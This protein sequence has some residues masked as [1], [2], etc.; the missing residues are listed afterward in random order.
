MVG[1]H[2][3][4]DIRQRLTAFEVDG[5]G[6]GEKGDFPVK[7][8]SARLA[9][10]YRLRAEVRLDHPPSGTPDCWAELLV[11]A[12][13][14]PD[15]A[16]EGYAVRLRELTGVPYVGLLRYGPDGTRVLAESLHGLTLGGEHHL[17]LRVDGVGMT[18]TVDDVEVLR[19]ADTE[20]LRGTQLGL[21]AFG[22]AARAEIVELAVSS[23]SP[24]PA[25]PTSRGT[26]P[27]STAERGTPL[28]VTGEATRVEVVPLWWPGGDEL[29][30]EVAAL[31][32]DHSWSTAVPLGDWWLA[33]GHQAQ[34]SDLRSTAD[35][36]RVSFTSVAQTGAREVLLRGEA[37]G[38]TDITLT[39]SCEVSYP[40]LELHALPVEE[41]MHV[42]LLHAFE[43]LDLENA[44]EVVCG[45]LQ[46]ARMVR[47]S[48]LLGASELTTPF[49]LVQRS[50]APLTWGVAVPGADLAFE[51]EQNRDP[52]DQ[53]FGMSLRG[54]DG[55]V[56]PTVCL[57]QPGRRALHGPK[58]P[59]RARVLAVLEPAG[60]HQTYRRLVR[61]EYGYRAYRESVFG[62]S[63]TD[64]VLN[65]V[66]LLATDPPEDDSVSYQGSPSGWW[67]RA[68]NWIDIENK[69]TVRSTTAGVM[70]S[71]A[72]LLDDPE[73][74]D[75]RARPLVEFHLSRNGYGWT[76][77]PGHRVYGDATRSR[78]CSTPVG[79]TTLGP[80]HD[81]MRRQNAGIKALADQV[82]GVSRDYW[83]QRS[84]VSLSLASYRLSDNPDEL[85]HACRL[86]DDYIADHIDRLRTDP[87]DPHD[88]AV[89]YVAD[90]ISLLELHL[91]TGEARYLEAAH[92]E[93]SRFATQVFVRPVPTGTATFPNRPQ[94]H[95]RQIELGRWWNP[96]DL[97]DYPREEVPTEKAERWMVSICGMA[98]EAVQTYRYSGPTLNPGWAPALLRL[99]ALTADDLL[100]DVAHNAMVG[101]FTNYPG[102][103]FRQQTVAPLRPDFPLTGPFDLTTLY[104]HHAPGQLGMVLDYLVTEHEVRSHGRIAFPAAFEENFV[105]FR[106]RTYGHRPGV[107][108]GREDV[109]LWMPRGV[110]TLDN[111]QISWLSGEQAGDTFCL[112]LSNAAAAQQRVTVRFGDQLR[113]SASGTHLATLY[114]GGMLVDVEIVDRALTVDVPAH[115]SVA[116]AVEGVGPLTVAMRPP[117]GAEIVG[118][119][120]RS[121]TYHFAEGTPVG[122][123]RALLLARPDGDGHDAYVQSDC[124]TPATLVYSLD[125][126][127]TWHEET[128]PVHPAE[129]TV[130]V[131]SGAP[132]LRYRVG[133]GANSSDEVR[134]GERTC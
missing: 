30:V 16:I 80:L 4:S 64:T 52:D 81:M 92:R 86:A 99:A 3:S 121:E 6:V 62:Q 44:A 55:A 36:I 122:A 105:W 79:I 102:Y 107:F 51:D 128:K 104:H 56:Q 5:T 39:I 1:A 21:R 134:I 103:Y 71:A 78:L 34:R 89:F 67:S 100:R 69:Q 25:P 114:A 28:V 59:L 43:G 117:L 26:P 40:S 29:L 53:P 37:E 95:D 9:T 65:L 91:E 119:E 73:L 113:L 54:P 35:L 20:R 38:Y 111:P 33:S 27:P 68:K 94:V 22:A 82:P 87:V 72:Y 7:L 49:A 74:Y 10:G 23:D 85:R 110:V 132:G 97:Y 41:G 2:S 70:L 96:E 57:P 58:R 118:A 130:R 98:L 75:R 50:G 108:H 60:L 19:T 90:W 32:D 116:L 129:W 101:R 83:L 84:P 15:G 120:Q 88:F 12:S 112:S 47:G 61:D 126:G 8:A 18:L 131:A 127:A 115:G 133:R 123:V 17:E 31:R 124:P 63:L 109:W 42:A 76:P 13:A 46:H 77:E 48:E 66:D 45:P 11:D 125:D 24:L 106:Y 93:A 14:L